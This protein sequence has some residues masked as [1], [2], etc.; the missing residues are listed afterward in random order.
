[1]SDVSDEYD[2][3]LGGLPRLSAMRLEQTH[4]EAAA[5][6]VRFVGDKPELLESDAIRVWEGLGRATLPIFERHT[7]NMLS[8]TLTPTGHQQVQENQSGWLLASADRTESVTLY[9][10]LVAVQTANY[11]RY[12]TSLGARLETV[13]KLFVETTGAR[14]INRIGLRFINRLQASDARD[15]RYWGQRIQPAFAGPLSWDFNNLVSAAH[16]QIELRLDDSAAARVIS[17]V[18]REAGGDPLYSFLVDLDV[19]REQAFPYEEPLCSNVARQLNRT[20]LSLFSEVVTR[21]YL[22]ELSQDEWGSAE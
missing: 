1:M 19:F 7:T 22:D 3:P 8:L 13:L 18:L 6:E 17:G 4:L 21:R 10:T 12:S 11:E 20:A 14:V 2:V 9:P 16:Q 5:A 15:P